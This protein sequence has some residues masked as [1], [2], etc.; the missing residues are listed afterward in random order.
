MPIPR[1]RVRSISWVTGDDQA[2]SDTRVA[3]ASGCIVL[4][5]KVSRLRL[6]PAFRLDAPSS[7]YPV[8]AGLDLATLSPTATAAGRFA[9]RAATPVA[10]AMALLATL[11]VTANTHRIGLSVALLA[12]FGLAATGKHDARVDLRVLKDAPSIA[13]WVAIALTGTLLLAPSMV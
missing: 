3:S 6:D 8:D 13:A 5:E 1:H 11:V 7:A 12:L 9:I 4:N 10:D 2:S